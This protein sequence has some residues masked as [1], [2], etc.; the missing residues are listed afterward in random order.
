MQTKNPATWLASTPRT[1]RLIRVLDVHR[2][3]MNRVVGQH[4]KR[5]AGELLTAAQWLARSVA[6]AGFG[7]PCQRR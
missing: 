1:T 6:A 4:F 5:V 2:M 3:R 7:E